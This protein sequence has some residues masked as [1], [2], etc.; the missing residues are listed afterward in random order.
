MMKNEK[1]TNKDGKPHGLWEYYYSNGQLYT[2]G[3][4]IN[5]NAD[6]LW[7]YYHYNGKLEIK[8]YYI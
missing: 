6:G 5:G 1:P 2:K 3:K 4:Y 8:K 7:E